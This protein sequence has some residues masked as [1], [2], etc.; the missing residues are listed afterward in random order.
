[1]KRKKPKFIRQTSNKM[2]KLGQ[3]RRKKQV[4][5][6]AKGRDSKV[7]LGE[8]AYVQR[9]KVGWG[10][11]KKDRKDIVIVRSVRELESVKVKE[12]LI[13][14]V[15]KK[16]RDEIIAKAKEKE[17]KI[18]NKYLKVKEKEDATR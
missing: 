11:C 10:G 16:K 2:S 14:S 4:W 1:M 6:K 12:I 5:R 3:G 9:V 18:L 8:K 13:G 15:G 7:R 17:I